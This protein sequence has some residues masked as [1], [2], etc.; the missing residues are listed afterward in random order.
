MGVKDIGGAYNRASTKCFSEWCLGAPIKNPLVKNGEKGC[1]D[2]CA[3]FLAP[4]GRT[5]RNGD[6]IFL[7][8]QDIQRHLQDDNKGP[9]IPKDIPKSLFETALVGLTFNARNNVV[10]LRPPR[11][12][13]SMQ[14]A[15]QDYPQPQ[16]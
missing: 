13:G 1:D 5:F 6:R 8:A 3:V 16:L 9:Y 11:E 10:T 12:E 2:F 4:V 7:T 14:M 15:A